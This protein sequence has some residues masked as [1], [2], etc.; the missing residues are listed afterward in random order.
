MSRTSPFRLVLER[1]GA[2]GPEWE[3]DHVSAR[4]STL[5]IR[6]AQRRL[7]LQDD[8]H[9]FPRVV[10]VEGG[11]VARAQFVDGCAEAVAAGQAFGS[12]AA[13]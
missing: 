3:E 12:R 9:L 11:E 5:S 13:A 6:R 1:M 10:K 4:E 7:T 2:V 8:E